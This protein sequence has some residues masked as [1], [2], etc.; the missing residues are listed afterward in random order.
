[1]CSETIYT[2]IKI[3]NPNANS[4]THYPDSYPD[5]FCRHNLAIAIE[6]VIDVDGVHAGIK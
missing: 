2:N 5:S 4:D 3:R 1:M 6:Q